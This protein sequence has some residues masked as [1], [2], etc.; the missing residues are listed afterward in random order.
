M[1]ADSNHFWQPPERR[2]VLLV[3]DEQ[4]VLVALRDALED[5]YDVLTANTPVAALELLEHAVDVAVVRA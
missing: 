3:D 2:R 5:D 1:Q 4:Q